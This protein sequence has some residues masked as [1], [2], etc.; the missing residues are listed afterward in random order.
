MTAIIK[1]DM[2]VSP[3]MMQLLNTVQ[4]WNMNRGGYEKSL[5]QQCDF[6]GKNILNCVLIRR[7][8]EN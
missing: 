4:N 2:N 1:L 6:L 8:S 5:S 7:W 3:Q